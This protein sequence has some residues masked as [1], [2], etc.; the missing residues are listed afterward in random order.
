MN[1]SFAVQWHSS[2]WGRCILVLARGNTRMTGGSVY[3][4]LTQAEWD[5]AIYT[6]RLLLQN[7]SANLQKEGNRCFSTTL[8]SAV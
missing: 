1:F 6:P 8:Y 7:Y 4:L 5:N 3:P 2:G